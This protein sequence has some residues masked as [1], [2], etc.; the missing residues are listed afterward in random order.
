MNRQD[1]RMANGRRQPAGS[2][3]NQPA[4]A[5]R[6]PLASRRFVLVYL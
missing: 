4:D 1:A 6:S 5:G 2:T 3:F